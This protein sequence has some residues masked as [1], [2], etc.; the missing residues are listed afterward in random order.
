MMMIFIGNEKGKR[1]ILSDIVQTQSFYIQR[2]Q[3]HLFC[4]LY[5]KYDENELSTIYIMV[6]D[7][8]SETFLDKNIQ[9]HMH[10]NAHIIYDIHIFQIFS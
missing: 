6:K 9:T 5:M 10:N 7:I 4:N 3:L 8:N 1:R 2:K